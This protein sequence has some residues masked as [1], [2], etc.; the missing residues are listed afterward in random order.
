MMA[1]MMM[2]MMMMVWRKLYAERQPLDLKKF[3]VSALW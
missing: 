2:M 3:T 1:I